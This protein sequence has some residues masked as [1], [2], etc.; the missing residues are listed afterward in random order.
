Q[1]NGATVGG[2]ANTILSSGGAG[3][4]T[5]ILTNG[6]GLGTQ[7]MTVSN[8]LTG[9]IINA[10][11]AVTI[12][13][14]MTGA[15]FTKTGAGA[16]TLT[17]SNL[18]SGNTVIR[19]G[20][21]MLGDGAYLNNSTL[22]LAGG[23]F[24]RLTQNI[25]PTRANAYRSPLIVSNTSY[26]VTTATASSR[27]IHFDSP[28]S[29]VAGSTLV[30]SNTATPGTNQFR[31]YA[32]GIKFAGNIFL[33][34][35]GTGNKAMLELY[36]TNNPAGG[37]DDVFTGFI[38]GGGSV[39]RSVEG[40]NL[41]G[42]VI[43]SNANI[44]V[45]GTEIRGGFIGLG[46][47]TCLGSGPVTIGGNSTPLGLYAVDAART[48]NNVITVDTTIANSTN[49]QINGSQNL[50]LGGRILIHTNL[51]QF[52]INNTALTTITGVVTNAGPTAAGIV[53]QGPGTLM[54]EATNTFNGSVVLAAG[55]LALGGNGAIASATNIILAAGT[56]FD[57]SARNTTLALGGSQQL[58]VTNWNGLTE[59]I[60][61]SPAAGLSL[62]TGTTMALMFSN[63]VP[64]VTVSNGTLTLNGGAIN[65]SVLGGPWPDGSYLLIDTTNG[66]AVSGTLPPFVNLNSPALPAGAFA[67]PQIAG[68]K[69]F[70]DYQVFVSAYDTGPGFF[71]GENLVHD[72][73]SGRSFYVWSTTNLSLPV[74]TWNF[75]GPTVEHPVS[76]STPAMSHYGITVTP[77]VSPTYYVFATT[78]L[79]P[80]GTNEPLVILTT[81]DFVSF[82]V[83]PTNAN[84]NSAG[85]F[86][87]PSAP[88]ITQ[89]PASLSLLQGQNAHF[90]V[91]AAG[92]AL[93]FQWY[94]NGGALPG[95]AVSNLV[96]AGVTAANA[97]SYFAVVTNTAGA[98]TSS[99]A[100]LW[101]AAMPDISL[102]QNSNGI[103]LA[104]SSVTGLNYIVQSATNLLAPT[105]T[106]VFTNVT[107]ADGLIQFQSSVRGPLQF[108][109]LMFP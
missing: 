100:M 17:A 93:N 39:Y 95:S 11:T 47:N 46:A 88:V 74:S 78:N 43:F 103:A 87:F 99:A 94:Q 56:S 90:T 25:T 107:D 64:A 101:I 3:T 10:A 19:A 37:S 104:G 81:D 34:S 96:L 51:M 98:A 12:Y 40:S 55:T 53:K 15:G 58:T 41:G 71:S 6:Q 82:T 14:L 84:V 22:V 75:E 38:S 76:G 52:T 91:A 2:V 31:L 68:G 62:G 48:L 85:V 49:L 28:V 77:S 86:S 23:T 59:N 18:Y 24:E 80:Y 54:L 4:T 5:L 29:C 92:T 70:L 21:L 73:F 27:T 36:N 9:G 63:G 26:I 35:T 89:Q 61:G 30:L 20:A 102:Q 79:G 8:N 109:R 45:G 44:Y 105:W 1:L 57:V 97:G 33:I 65:A 16:L 69:L 32:G 13:S 60:A 83:T 106:P 42:N 67:V 50:T 66:G 72:D 7:N 108:Y